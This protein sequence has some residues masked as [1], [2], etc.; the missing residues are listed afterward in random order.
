MVAAYVVV[1]SRTGPRVPTAGRTPVRGRR[2]PRSPRSGGPPPA[3]P[4][5]GAP[6][7]PSTCRPTACRATPMTCRCCRSHW[8][9][10]TQEVGVGH[11]TAPSWVKPVAGP[12]GQRRRRRR[13][14]AA[15][16]RLE[17]P[18]ADTGV[19]VVEA[20]R[21]RTRT[22]TDRPPGRRACSGSRRRRCRPPRAAAPARRSTSRWRTPRATRSLARGVVVVAARR[23]AERRGDTGDAGEGRRVGA[24]AGALREGSGAVVALQVVPESVAIS[25]CSRSPRVPVT[26][27]GHAR[28]RRRAGD[29]EQEGVGD[30]RSARRWP[31]QGAVAAFHRRPGP[32]GQ[33][34]HGRLV[35]PG[36]VDVPAHGDTE[37]DRGTTRRGTGWS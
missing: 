23:R 8:P 32:V 17:Q 37:R 24:G 9:T 1:A 10:A 33:G 35:P 14:P 25:P 13:P 36:R 11:E 12:R 7:R 19:V 27:H 30:V 15:V 18:V 22:P 31:R 21:R 20:L 28:R 16:P 3:R 4:S 34:V 6:G 5:A 26:T 29:R 2:P